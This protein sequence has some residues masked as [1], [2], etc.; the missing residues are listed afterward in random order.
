M[1]KTL[2]FLLTVILSLSC[3]F[4]YQQTY[5]ADSKEYKEMITLCNLSGIQPANMISPISADQMLIILDDIPYEKLSSTAQEYYDSLK[6]ELTHPTVDIS[7]GKNTVGGMKLNTSVSAQVLLQGECESDFLIPKKNRKP[8]LYLGSDIFFNNYAFGTFNFDLTDIDNSYIPGTDDSYKKFTTNFPKRLSIT[9]NVDFA[10]PHKAF[11]SIGAK[12]M[13]V[14]V[15]R[16]RLSLGNGNTGNLTLGNNF[17]Y[18]DFFK[19]SIVSGSVSY[20]FLI[21]SFEDSVG[22]GYD[23]WDIGNDST[24]SKP[25]QLVFIHNFSYKPISCLSLTL[26]EGCLTYGSTTL[27]DFRK[28]N[29]FM[30]LHNICDYSNGNNNTGNMNNFFGFEAALTLPQGFTFDFQAV[31]DQIQVSGEKNE[32][33]P[34]AANGFKLGVKR[35]DTFLGGL[36]NYYVEAAYTSPNL[37]LKEDTVAN[38]EYYNLDL[39]VGKKLFWSTSGFDTAS[40]LGY[41]YGPDSFVLGTGFNWVN[42]AG[43]EFDC[44][45]LFRIH[46]TQGICYYRNQND[47]AI[48]Y[49]DDSSR[50]TGEYDEKRII[51]DVGATCPITKFLSVNGEVG[52]IHASNYHNEPGNYNSF[53]GAVSVTIVPDAFIK[54]TKNL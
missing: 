45:A 20:D 28:I 31:F 38:T 39:I 26:T 40:Y 33:N 2:T 15:G 51:L 48:F 7:L 54:N 10:S 37:Y 16:D 17:W 8:V 9:D 6:N 22:G 12:G 44:S 18:E 4:A 43:F 11:A 1:K 50:I 46:G 13:N 34:Q 52:F 49:G 14:I 27:M 3:I 47:S 35:S 29:P 42:E 41:Q 19:A 53:Q 5:N 30:I 23:A 21:M 24:G 25:H 32:D 36:A